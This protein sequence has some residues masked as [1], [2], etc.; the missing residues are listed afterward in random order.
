MD[1]LDVSGKK[2]KEKHVVWECLRRV[3]RW[4]K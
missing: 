4:G 1:P 2:G 3:M